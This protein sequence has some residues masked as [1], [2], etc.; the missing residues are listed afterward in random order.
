MRDPI[1]AKLEKAPTARALTGLVDPEGS[2]SEVV[3]SEVLVKKLRNPTL[4]DRFMFLVNVLKVE[5]TEK[6]GIGIPVMAMLIAWMFS[7]C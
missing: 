3:C 4:K 1:P 6:L 7:E 2:G 5:Q